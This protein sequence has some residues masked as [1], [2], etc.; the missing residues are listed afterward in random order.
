MDDIELKS[1]NDGVPDR[2]GIKVEI[3]CGETSNDRFDMCQLK[4]CNEV[5]VIR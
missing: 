2:I 5:N 4:I 1:M 3:W